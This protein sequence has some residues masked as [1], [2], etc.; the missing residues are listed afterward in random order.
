MVEDEKQAFKE[1]SKAFLTFLDMCTIGRCPENTAKRSKPQS[2]IG[3]VIVD[4]SQICTIAQIVH[5]ILHNDQHNYL[6]RTKRNCGKHNNGGVV[7]RIWSLY[8]RIAG[9]EPDAA[10]ASSHPG[11]SDREDS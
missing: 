3:P 7:Q 5:L 6:I 11:C 9:G 8:S 2:Q 10:V 1:L 4:R